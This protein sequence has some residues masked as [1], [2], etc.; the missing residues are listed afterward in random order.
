MVDI[1]LH[2]SHPIHHSHLHHKGEGGR[3]LRSSVNNGL[4]QNSDAI[5]D[6]G[7]HRM[8]LFPVIFQHRF[9]EYWCVLWHCGETQRWVARS[10]IPRS[11][12]IRREKMY[13]IVAHIY[14]EHLLGKL[15]Y[16]NSQC[17]QP[18]CDIANI[19][20][21]P[22]SNTETPRINPSSESHKCSQE[23]NLRKFDPQ[24]YSDSLVQKKH[25]GKRHWLSYNVSR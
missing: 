18:S 21:P 22:P 8:G 24:E 20:L 17:S 3:L 1:G 23:L 19:S 10:P 2:T 14:T 7:R 11:Y 6:I 15:T 25:G 5:Q 4:L 16:I 9:V 12:C 13:T